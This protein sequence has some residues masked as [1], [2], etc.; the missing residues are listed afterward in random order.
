MVTGSFM[1]DLV[2][3]SPAK[4]AFDVCK[5]FINKMDI[6]EEIL[7]INP[8][9]Y[10]FDGR[11]TA[12]FIK[13]LDNSYQKVMLFGHNFAF[14]DLANKFGNIFIENLPT[15]GLVMINFNID[16]WKDIDKGTTELIIFPKN[17]R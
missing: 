2:V 17:L 10:D 16:L 15:S 4:R 7:Q 8:T 14:T 1:P 13:F 12:D 5:I 9:I 6:S 11:K 3:S